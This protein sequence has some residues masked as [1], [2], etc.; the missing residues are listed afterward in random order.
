MY[1]NYQAVLK[2]MEVPH[3]Y[4]DKYCSHVTN[5]SRQIHCGIM[6]AADEGI[7]QIVQALRHKVSKWALKGKFS[8]PPLADK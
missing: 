4:I 6:A 1:L 7:G 3:Q 8:R 2:P 5:A